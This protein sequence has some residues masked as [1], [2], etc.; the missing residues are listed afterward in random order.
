MAVNIPYQLINNAELSLNTYI[1]AKLLALGYVIGDKE[2]EIEVIESWIDNDF[3]LPSMALSLKRDND[4]ELSLG[5][6]VSRNYIMMIH[7]FGRSSLERKQLADYLVSDFS[8]NVVALLNYN[9]DPATDDGY[10]TLENVGWDTQRIARSD[11]STE[12]IAVIT[13]EVSV[14]RNLSVSP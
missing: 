2:G 1:E 9:D 7:I 10:M 12:N 14:K 3:T 11:D 8:D 4:I 13:A 5:V 6:D